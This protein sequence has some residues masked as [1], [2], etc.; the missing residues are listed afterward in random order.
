MTLID[1]VPE[2]VNEVLGA[3]GTSLPASTPPERVAAA[4]EHVEDVHGWVEAAAATT[5]AAL[6]DG[7][8]AALVVDLPLFGVGQHLGAKDYN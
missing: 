8:L 1:Y 3:P 4:E 2:L 5:W 7:L 6:L